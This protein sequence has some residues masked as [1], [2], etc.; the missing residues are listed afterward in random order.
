MDNGRLPDVP[1]VHKAMGHDKKKNYAS[2]AVPAAP[3]QVPSQ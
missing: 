2:V 1:Y 3:V